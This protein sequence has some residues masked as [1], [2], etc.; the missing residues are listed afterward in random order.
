MATSFDSVDGY[1]ASFPP[2]VQDIVQLLRQSIARAIPG[3]QESI[4][5][6]MPVMG[7]DGKYVVHFA[8][9]KR[10]IGMYPI[11]VFDE[12]LEHE[13]GPYR[14]A[15]DTI[16]FPYSKPIPFDL[17]ERVTAVLVRQRQGLA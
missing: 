15:K 3:L 6:N 7:C 13:V 14:A 16:R 11:P 17:V 12:L 4:R 5:Y 1:I 8:G 2:E 10:H 9:W